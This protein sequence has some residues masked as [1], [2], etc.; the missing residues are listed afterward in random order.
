MGIEEVLETIVYEAQFASM[1]W[2]QA[3]MNFHTISK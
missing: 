3:P 2:F 1:D